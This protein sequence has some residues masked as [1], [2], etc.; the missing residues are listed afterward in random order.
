MMIFPRLLSSIL[1]LLGPS[2]D[3]DTP[4]PYRFESQVDVVSV[5]VAVTDKEGN[6]I[7]DL[8]P[9]DFVVYEDGKRQKISLFAAGLEESWVGLAPD[10]KEELSGSQV[11]GLLMDASGSMETEMRLVR[12]AAVKFLSNIPKTEHLC[13]IDFDENIRVSSYTSDD[14]RSITER[15]DEIEAEGWTAL[16]DAVVT[17][18]E[19]TYGMSG[20][21]TLVVFSDGVDSRSILGQGECYDAVKTCDVT[22]HSIQFG[23]T[24]KRDVRRAHQQGRFL[25]RISELTGGSYSLATTLESI[26]ELYDRI[27]EELFSQYTLGYVSTNT[28]RDGRYRK[29][30][31]EV[32]RD[33]VKWRSRQGYMGPVSFEEEVE[34]R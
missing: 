12:Q 32:L 5:P 23:H 7:K 22:I 24:I 31:V 20:K 8:G 17:F 4:Q 16:Y 9:E 15:I 14:Q 11:I 29:I 30:K 27:L 13:I 21:K 26:D 1:L 18:L 6:F 33:D 19:R 2:Q 34:K 3:R 28:E 25:H 10:L